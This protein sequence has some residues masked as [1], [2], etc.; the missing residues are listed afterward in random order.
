MLLITAV[1]FELSVATVFLLGLLT[2]ALIVVAQHHI[3]DT[4]MR[5]GFLPVYDVLANGATRVMF[6]EALIDTV[7]KE[8]TRDRRRTQLRTIIAA[9]A[10]A[11]AGGATIVL[12]ADKLAELAQSVTEAVVDHALERDDA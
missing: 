3:V 8:K 1:L 12:G 2:A 7:K 6:P 5:Q 10:S 4:G 9:A 11:V